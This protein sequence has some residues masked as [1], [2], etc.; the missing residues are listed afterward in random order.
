MLKRLFFILFILLFVTGAAYAADFGG[1]VT[2]IGTGDA[3]NIGHLA[4][5]EHGAHCY[6]V[7]GDSS[8]TA[9]TVS[10][11]GSHDGNH[12]FTLSIDESDVIQRVFS[13]AE[14]TAK[15]ADFYVTGAPVSLVRF[16]LITL[17]DENSTDT[18]YCTYKGK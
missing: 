8:I 16:N 2:V 3:I 12:W 10:L 5:S 17:T 4:Q 14:I 11:E 7:D 6:Y 18:L 9:V 15:Q 1:G 13:S